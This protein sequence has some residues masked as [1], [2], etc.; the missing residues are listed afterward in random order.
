MACFIIQLAENDTRIA[1]AG[2]KNPL[3]LA[4][5]PGKILQNITSLYSAIQGHNLSFYLQP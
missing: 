2:T 4:E 1:L 5:G 3:L